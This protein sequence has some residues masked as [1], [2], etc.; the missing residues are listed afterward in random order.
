MGGWRKAMRLDAGGDGAKEMVLQSIFDKWDEPDVPVA[1]VPDWLWELPKPSRPSIT[2]FGYN[3]KP[4]AY[5]GD[6]KP[7]IVGE[8]K[9]G[10]KFE[11]FAVAEVL[12]YAHLLRLKLGGDPIL[13]LVIS[14]PNYCIRAAITELASPVLRH[15]EADLLSLD[16]KTLLWLSCP[17]AALSEEP[18]LPADVPLEQEWSSL[19]WSAVEGEQTWIAHNGMH[20]PPFLQGAAAMLSRFRNGGR[21]EWVLWVGTLPAFGVEWSNAQWAAAGDF[22]IW[23]AK[24]MTKQTL[25]RPRFSSP[26]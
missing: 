23:D 13:S 9:Y 19:R 1:G 11:P 21:Y 26:R 24:A 15:I 6:S 8:L 7:R 17:H 20:E 3:S 4:D 5:W 18:P 10:A 22:W 16:G 12:H 2:S 14:Q 25:P